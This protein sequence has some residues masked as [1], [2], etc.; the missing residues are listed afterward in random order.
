MRGA[1]IFLVS[2]L[3]LL[4][5][6]PVFADYTVSNGTV[7]DF[8]TYGNTNAQGSTGIPLRQ[9][10]GSA[11]TTSGAGNVNTVTFW[12]RD[13]NVAAQSIPFNF[14]IWTS[15]GTTPAVHVATSSTF[16][17]GTAATQDDC[18]QYSATFSNV[19]LNASTEYFLVVGSWDNTITPIL[20]FPCI[21]IDTDPWKKTQIGTVSG[22]VWDVN[23][24]VNADFAYDFIVTEAA[25]PPP[26]PPTPMFDFEWVSFSTST[27]LAAAAEYSSGGFGS[28][29]GVLM[30]IL[31]L[32]V[33][34]YFVSFIIERIK[35]STGKVTNGDK[36]R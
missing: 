31:G 29:V 8:P 24:G 12:L 13:T 2:I 10:S 11:F 7:R 30:M 1:T 36:Y 21:V 33:S 20:I 26:P 27:S 3:S 19:P 35:R 18:Y 5:A 16:T 4:V 28:I 25:P 6:Q 15:N 9:F 32:I 22:G 34:G 17:V 23:P 14:E